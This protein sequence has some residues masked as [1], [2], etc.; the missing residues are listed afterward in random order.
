MVNILPCFNNV[1]YFDL[2]S[3]R[4]GCRR[5]ATPWSGGGS[6]SSTVS[7]S[8][9]GFAWAVHGC[10]CRKR[11]SRWRGRGAG[12]SRAGAPRF[13]TGPEITSNAEGTGAPPWPGTRTA[14]AD[15]GRRQIAEGRAGGALQ[16][17]VRRSTAAEGSIAELPRW[18]TCHSSVSTLARWLWCAVSRAK[19]KEAS[20]A[21]RRA[22]RSD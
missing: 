6:T 1:R 9:I 16:Q 10:C 14:S 11:R 4:R 13:E 3:L 17:A 12:G 21:G 2:I 15:P 7:A 8:L 20:R 5:T 19:V 18:P 22:S